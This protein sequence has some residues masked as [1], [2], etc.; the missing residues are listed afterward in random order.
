MC[1]LLLQRISLIIR[2]LRILVNWQLNR[3]DAKNSVFAEGWCSHWRSINF[4]LSAIMRVCSRAKAWSSAVCQDLWLGFLLLS[5]WFCFSGLQYVHISEGLWGAAV[6]HPEEAVLAEWPAL[7]GPPLPRHR[8]LPFLPRQQ[9]WTCGLEETSGKLV[10]AVREFQVMD[11]FGL[12]L[13][14]ESKSII[15]T[16][17]AYQYSTSNGFP[18]VWDKI[19][20]IAVLNDSNLTILC[21]VGKQTS[22]CF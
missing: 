11:V 2:P 7:W 18:S 5:S 6:L 13:L 9:N 15:R 10:C 21:R 8:W 19:A 12:R 17:G 1:T 4:S 14:I 16:H 3:Y 22:L 20:I